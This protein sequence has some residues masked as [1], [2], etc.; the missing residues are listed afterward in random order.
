[1]L[2]F[3]PSA[4]ESAPHDFEQSFKTAAGLNEKLI[5]EDNVDAV[6]GPYGSPSPAR[7]RN[8]TLTFTWWA[9]LGARII[10]PRHVS[11][12]ALAD[13]RAS[14]RELPAIIDLPR[15]P[16]LDSD[17]WFPK[18]VHDYEATEGT[19]SGCRAAGR[20]NKTSAKASDKRGRRRIA[21]GRDT[22]RA[23]C[24][25]VLPGE[26]A[27]AFLVELDGWGGTGGKSW[28]P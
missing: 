7:L 5:V 3:E 9:Q 25:R 2:D 16:C 12:I 15:S 21:V 8:S 6:L 19:P 24:C 17:L 10:T 13:I 23:R 28:K 26:L 18:F 14:R 27:S 1:M 4:P 20:S 11:P 22:R